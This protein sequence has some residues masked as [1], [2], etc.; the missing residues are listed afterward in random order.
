MSQIHK[1]A[2][3]VN[4][5]R[6]EERLALIINIEQIDDNPDFD[7]VEAI[8]AASAEY[9]H[10][11]DGKETLKNNCGE[12]NYGDFVNHVPDVIN[13]KHGFTLDSSE[14]THIVIDHDESLVPDDLD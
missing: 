6:A 5:Y 13:L 8:Q 1:I 10:T 4:S 14:T 9:L 2:A 12:F 11:A 7:P 3:V